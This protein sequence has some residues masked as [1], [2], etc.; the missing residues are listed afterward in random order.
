MVRTCAFTTTMPPIFFAIALNLVGRRRDLA[1]W[2]GMPRRAECPF[3]LIPDVH[4]S[5]HGRSCLA[6][7]PAAVEDR[8]DCA[9]AVWR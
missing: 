2:T 3:R 9:P 6:A 5:A 7:G 1:R 8:D 4:R